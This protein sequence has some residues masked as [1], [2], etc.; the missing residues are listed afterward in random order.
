MLQ[1]VGSVAAGIAVA[2][3]VKVLFSGSA[4]ARRNASA[5]AQLQ[6]NQQAIRS[7]ILGFGPLSG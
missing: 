6:A 7:Q 5:D 3:S 1:I 2:V 4:P